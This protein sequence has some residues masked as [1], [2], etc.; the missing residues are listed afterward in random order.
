MLH[1]S[2]ADMSA[3]DADL[4]PCGSTEISKG[5][6]MDQIVTPMPSHDTHPRA[7][8]REWVGLG[9]LALPC[10]LYS[11]DLTVLNLAVPHL[12]ADLKPSASQLLWIVDIYGFMVAGTLITMGTFGDRI[13]RRKLLMIGAGAFGIASIFAAFATS[14]EMLIVARALLGIAAATLA[15]STLSLIRNMFLDPTERSYAIGIWIA[16]F[17]AGGAIGPLVG[18]LLLTWFWWGSV[19]LIAV[20]VMVLLLVLAPLLLP[21]FR[22]PDAGRLDLSS[23]ALSLVA[24]LSVIYGMKATAEAGFGVEALV[25][26]AVGLALGA[27]FV[28]RQRRLASPLVD[29]SLFRALPFSASLGVNVFGFFVAFGSFLLIAQYLQLVIGLSPLAAGLWSAP[30]A[31][32]FIVGSMVAP[33]LASRVRAGVIMA[34]GLALATLG[35][36]LLSL[37]DGPS[38]L[39]TVVGGYVVLSLG[40]APVFTLATDLIIGAAPA[41]RAG[42]AAGI[43][44][45]SSEFGGALGIAVLG[46]V[47]AAVYRL[48]VDPMLP[49]GLDSGSR[50]IAI[51]T[52]GGAVD[53]ARGIG[54][55]IG[56]GLREAARDA[57]ALAF[58]VAALIS[59]AVALLA[60]CA[61]VIVLGR[62]RA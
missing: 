28:R 47:A 6:F 59:A 29:L 25:A 38:A 14:A 8:R 4:R 31:A 3:G 45:T 27:V 19:F 18:G 12:S 11:M 57:Y 10:L 9:V 26:I 39:A 58:R 13:G 30:S 48:T 33:A 1:R 51:D 55:E 24:V 36:L 16:S 43:A 2:R 62:E 54:G 23:A 44:E 22:D 53:L 56:D 32:A 7:T 20:P 52:V 50:A 34:G 37:A 15:P 49:A 60:T 40:L 42:A 46:S 61:T 35:L 5:N 17:S 41:E 21:E